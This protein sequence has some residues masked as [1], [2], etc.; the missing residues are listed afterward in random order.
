MASSQMTEQGAGTVAD[1]AKAAGSVYVKGQDGNT[2]VLSPEILEAFSLRDAVVITAGDKRYAIPRIVVQQQPVKDEERAAIEAVLDKQE[3]PGA[4]EDGEEAF[5]YLGYTA[6]FFG[7]WAGG[8][9]AI[10]ASGY[11]KGEWM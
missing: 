6:C 1:K 8:G 5:R 11:C 9:S 10:E 7:A 2:Y 3:L 4:S